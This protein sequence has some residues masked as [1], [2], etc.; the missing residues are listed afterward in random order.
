[1]G[2]AERTAT[3]DLT[4]PFASGTCRA[5]RSR[6][7][8]ADAVAV[9][10]LETNQGTRQGVSRARPGDVG[11]TLTQCSLTTKVVREGVGDHA[12]PTSEPGR[13][14]IDCHHG[15][16]LRNRLVQRE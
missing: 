8:L 11:A 3:V 10:R 5:V 7:L 9:R 13:R 1:M 15:A 12:R 4:E 14:R 2:V 6:R 16:R